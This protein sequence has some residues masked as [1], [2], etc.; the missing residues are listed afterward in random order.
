MDSR[1]KSSDVIAGWEDVDAAA[2]RGFVDVAE[3]EDNEDA[4]QKR[5][6]KR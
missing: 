4:T 3:E 5:R 1:K 2:G 6:R